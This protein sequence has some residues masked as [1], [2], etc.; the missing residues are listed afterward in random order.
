MIAL[1]AVSMALGLSVLGG[2]MMLKSWHIDVTAFGWVPLVSLSFVVFVSQ[3]GVL[4]L[5]FIVLAEIFPEKIKDG[6]VSFCMSLLWLFSFIIIKYL[7]L[8]MEVLTFYGSM[9][10]FA[11]IC[12]AGTV[13][14]LSVMPETKCKSHAEIM[15]SLE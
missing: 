2:Y 14:I 6:C 10:L 5:V 7:P 15:K 4:S 8:L 12:M 3:L 9:Y 1:S 11:A 13:F